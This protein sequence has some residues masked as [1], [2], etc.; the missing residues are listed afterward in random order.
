MIYY[1]R[2]HYAQMKH[3][4]KVRLDGEDDIFTE[5]IA[6]YQRLQREILATKRKTLIAL[7][8]SGII[9]DEALRKIQYDI[10]MEEVRL[11]A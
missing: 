7:R 6:V 4:H 9:N 10:D 11:P 5:R 1:A 8:D 3:K 2:T